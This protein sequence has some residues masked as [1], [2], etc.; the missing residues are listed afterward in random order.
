MSAT[1][2]DALQGVPT[3]LLE[4][5]I[6]R[7]RKIS[8]GAMVVVNAVASAFELTPSEV[9]AKHKTGRGTK[10]R[11]MAMT[12]IRQRGL[13]LCEVAA[14]FGCSSHSTVIQAAKRHWRDLADA[15]YWERRQLALDMLTDCQ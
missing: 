8:A 14:V 13:S 5:E 12:M 15:Y 2:S 10:A 1:I 9:I 4:A 6:M 7:R 3:E 11:Q